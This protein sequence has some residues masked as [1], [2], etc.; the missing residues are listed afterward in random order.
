MIDVKRPWLSLSILFKWDVCIISIKVL[1][2]YIADSG[3]VGA[4][5]KMQMEFLEQIVAHFVHNA[6]SEFHCHIP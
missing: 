3:L 5:P 1:A 6:H 4:K 2:I